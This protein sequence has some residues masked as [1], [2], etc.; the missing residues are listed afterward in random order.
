MNHSLIECF[1]LS[2]KFFPPITGEV[3]DVRPEL[4]PVGSIPEVEVDLLR[5]GV[6]FVPS[7]PCQVTLVW[8]LPVEDVFEFFV[9]PSVR[10]KMPMAEVEARSKDC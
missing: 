9:I 8:L 5:W 3:L 7:F 1:L 10:Y 2:I 6:Q 4:R